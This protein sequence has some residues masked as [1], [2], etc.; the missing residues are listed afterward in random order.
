MFSLSAKRPRGDDIEDYLQHD[1]KV[2]ERDRWPPLTNNPVWNSSD[3][4]QK[5]QAIVESRN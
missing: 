1:S 4:R 3:P 5:D 2:R